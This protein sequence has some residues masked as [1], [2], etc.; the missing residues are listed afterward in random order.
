M[1]KTSLTNNLIYNICY[2]ILSLIVPLITA[3]YISRVLGTSGL[4]EYS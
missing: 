1:K 2:Q 3:P 4:G